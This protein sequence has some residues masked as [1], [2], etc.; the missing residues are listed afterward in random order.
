M[1]N[2][3][4]ASSS[5]SFWMESEITLKMFNTV[6]RA[7][8]LIF[9]WEHCAYF[10]VNEGRETKGCDNKRIPKHLS[11]CAAQWHLCVYFTDSFDFRVYQFNSLQN[12]KCFDSVCE[13]Q[14]K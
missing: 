6:A 14:E 1:L 3:G 9:V 5:S 4:N 13:F 12:D 10:A 2:E 11:L 7:S 8:Q